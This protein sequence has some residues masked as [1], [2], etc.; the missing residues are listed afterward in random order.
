MPAMPPYICPENG[1]RRYTN[2]GVGTP[3][4][5]YPVMTRYT[6]MQH[7]I[8]TMWDTMEHVDMLQTHP[9]RTGTPVRASLLEGMLAGGVTEILAALMDERVKQNTDL[10][11]ESELASES[12]AFQW[13]AP[14]SSTDIGH[15]QQDTCLDQ[16]YRKTPLITVESNMSRIYPD[17]STICDGIHLRPM[18]P[19][20]TLADAEET[21]PPG[22]KPRKGHVTPRGIYDR[23]STHLLNQ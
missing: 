5:L 8:N 16:R 7:T 10:A 12:G 3:E 22:V 6:R 18:L 9:E 1:L 14:N 2:V 13:Q 17:Y 20:K 4:E 11:S 15:G 23:T 21:C 19:K